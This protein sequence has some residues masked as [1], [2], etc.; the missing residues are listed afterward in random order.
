MLQKITKFAN[1][2]IFVFP[3]KT[4]N[5]LSPRDKLIAK[6]AT[7]IL[8]AS[9][10]TVLIFKKIKAR[11]SSSKENHVPPKDVDQNSTQQTSDQTSPKNKVKNSYPIV[12][13]NT[14]SENYQQTNV[15]PDPL[16]SVTSETSEII[17]TPKE[18]LQD[19]SGKNKD[20]LG[21]QRR[22]LELFEPQTT[23]E[24]PKP[25]VKDDQS[26]LRDQ[27]SAKEQHEPQDKHQI[28]EEPAVVIS[29][30]FE[31]VAEKTI[32]GFCEVDETL[33]QTDNNEVGKRVKVKV[34]KNKMAPLFKEAEFD[35]EQTPIIEQPQVSGQK[36]HEQPPE[37]VEK[38]H[39]VEQI[40]AKEKQ[41]E[42]Q[43]TDVTIDQPI[44]KQK[45]M[46]VLESVITGV[47]ARLKK[48][49][50]YLELDEAAKSF[51]IDK[52]FQQ[53]MG[54]RPL[55]RIIQQDIEDPLAE[56]LL[57]H[58]SQGRR[59]LVTVKN[60]QLVLIDKEVFS[61]LKDKDM[62]KGEF[63]HIK[64]LF[65]D[66]LSLN[67]RVIHIKAALEESSKVR[68]SLKLN[69]LKDVETFLKLDAYSKDQNNYIESCKLYGIINSTFSTKE[70]RI[71]HLGEQLSNEYELILEVSKKDFYWNKVT[72]SEYKTILKKID[73]QYFALDKP[74]YRQLKARKS[75]PDFTVKYGE[76]IRACKAFKHAYQMR[77][78][79]DLTKPETANNISI[80]FLSAEIE[81]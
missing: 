38:P 56:K 35:I 14:N 7:L 5:A 31:K 62:E 47:Q 33:P 68:L 10:I 2:T 25:A 69:N 65:A 28:I 27:Q 37:V 29:E 61:I 30:K 43:L 76:F 16:V 46:E 72:R 42:N 41:Q 3:Q 19:F 70:D 24:Q 9:A 34:S 58:P 75:D 66:G 40:Q 71:K 23:D 26:S 54:A 77:G 50:V 81:I 1:E 78:W 60:D 57:A 67:D 51:L 36:Q 32:T 39:V 8:F 53:E 64:K 6:V 80:F 52:G 73:S 17:E 49:E 79:E 18:P 44:N 63:I 45:L 55:T 11:K 20:I 22:V 59:C 15:K 21:G 4:W 12:K 13:A 48:R 74:T